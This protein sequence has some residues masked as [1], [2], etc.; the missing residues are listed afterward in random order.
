MAA[1]DAHNFSCAGN[2]TVGFGQ[3][4]KDKFTLVGFSRFA[5]RV[6]IE[7]GSGGSVGAENGQVVGNVT[8]VSQPFDGY[9]RIGGQSLNFWPAASAGFFVGGIA[10]VEIYNRPLVI[11]E[12][13]QNFNINRGRFGL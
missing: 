11:A 12:I 8:A 5:I 2:I 6:K 13:E 7:A 1:I 3:F 4:T 10:A 9:W